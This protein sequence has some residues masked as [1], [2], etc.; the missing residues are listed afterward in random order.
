MYRRRAPRVYRSRVE[1]DHVELGEEVLA[2]AYLLLLLIGLVCRDTMSEAPGRDHG[3]DRTTRHWASAASKSQA[4]AC[5]F[6]IGRYMQDRAKWRVREL[7]KAFAGMLNE[8]VE[9]NRG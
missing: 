6:T 2:Y 7:L 5:G 9:E 1:E 3:V 8:W 4:Q